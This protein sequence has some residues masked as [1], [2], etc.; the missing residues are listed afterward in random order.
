MVA[1][2]ALLH[3]AL[4][5]SITSPS[6]LTVL[7]FSRSGALQADFLITWTSTESLS[8]ST[9]IKLCQEV[10]G[11][12]PCRTIASATANDGRYGV[13][14]LSW[15]GFPGWGDDYY[16]DITVDCCTFNDEDFESARFSIRCAPS[17]YPTWPGDGEC[18]AGC[19]NAAC[20]YDEG[21]CA[22]EPSSTQS[23]TSY[24]C[25]PREQCPGTQSHCC[26]DGGSISLVGTTCTCDLPQ[27]CTPPPTPFPT[28]YPTPP[29]TEPRD[30]T[31][32]YD[33]C[34]ATN[35]PSGGKT[36]LE[37]SGPMPKCSCERRQLCIFPPTS[38]PTSS[39]SSSQENEFNTGQSLL[40][41][42]IIELLL[43]CVCV[44]SFMVC[45]VLLCQKQAR[46]RREAAAPVSQAPARN[47]SYASISLEECGPARQ[48]PTGVSTASLP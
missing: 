48:G 27:T 19:N 24:S 21:D 39:S 31:G 8:D 29:P 44:S 43:I 22:N 17:C 18:D 3:V 35:C 1:L 45:T 36:Y 4:S 26:P 28:P 47:P 30:V 12:D 33:C 37:G 23:S 41:F 15:S 2:A 9:E 38:R 20:G 11:V 25:C 5:G 34:Y 16:I 13:S 14:S 10:Y 46:K 7:Y 42:S 32:D 6:T 40:S